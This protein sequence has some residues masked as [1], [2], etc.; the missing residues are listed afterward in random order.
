MLVARPSVVRA[1][2]S[3]E[4]AE[5]LINYELL[6]QLFSLADTVPTPLLVP[7][8]LI[9]AT[10][11]IPSSGNVL[12]LSVVVATVGTAIVCVLMCMGNFSLV[13]KFT[14]PKVN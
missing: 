11:L 12:K 2:Y 8:P 13:Q 3:T 6:S 10:L 4:D 9:Q 14:S 7:C 1:L 5:K